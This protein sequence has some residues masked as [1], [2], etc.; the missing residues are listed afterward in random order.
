M[1]NKSYVKQAARTLTKVFWNHPPLQYC[2]PDEAEREKVAPYF[3]SLSLSNGI[4]YGEVHA[5]S[6]ELEGIA[7]WLPSDNY[8]VTMWKLLRSVPLSDIFGFGKYGGSRMRGLGQHIDLVHSKQAPF[9]H[10]F[11]QA[12]GVDSQFQGKGYASKLIR[13]MLSRIDEEGLPCYLET[14][15]EQNVLLY[16]HFG[17]EI[18]E[19][20]MIPKTSL[21]NWAM[22]RQGS[23]SR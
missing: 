13:P 11:L 5:T 23:L 20:S 6:P 2:Y 17:F 15:E 16:E 18:V 7:I 9:K 4:R 12:I 10:L 3:F 8:P 22:L 19:E 14:L 21:T 1:L